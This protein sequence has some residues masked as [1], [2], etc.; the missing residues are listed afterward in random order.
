MLGI[1]RHVLVVLLIYA[2]LI[3]LR[4]CELRA[5]LA[6]HPHLT[7]GERM[8]LRHEAGLATPAPDQRNSGE[9]APL[10]ELATMV[11]AATEYVIPALLLAL[12]LL[13]WRMRQPPFVDAGRALPDALTPPPRTCLA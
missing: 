8:A 5:E 13:I 12:A 1:L 11:A 3:C 6:G 10:N 4:Y 9:H 7:P 2:P